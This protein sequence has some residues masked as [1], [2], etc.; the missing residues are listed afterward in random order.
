MTTRA[1]QILNQKKISF[2]VIRYNHEEKGAL[3]ASRAIHFPLERTAKTLVADSGQYKYLLALIPGNRRV[4]PKNLAKVHGVKRVAMADPTAAERIT[5]YKIGGIS[6]VG[7]RQT[8]P[9]IM[10]ASLFKFKQIVINGGQ[11]GIMLKMAPTDI[12]SL[13]NAKIGDIIK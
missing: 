4:S 3:F 13:L 1:I 9:V 8:L 10:E 2:E 12:Q 7:T 5:G 6:P 11:R